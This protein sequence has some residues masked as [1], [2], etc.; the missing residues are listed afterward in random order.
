[1]LFKKDKMNKWKYGLSLDGLDFDNLYDI[2]GVDILKKYIGFLE[3]CHYA[4]ESYVD[5]H[6]EIEF[7]SLGFR[8]FDILKTAAPDWYDEIDIWNEKI[9]DRKE[10]YQKR[11]F[12][13]MQSCSILPLNKDNEFVK[14]MCHL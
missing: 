1:M 8:Y 14:E 9:S 4:V 5:N 6:P 11:M 12:N 3:R 13:S 2:L 7:R 10:E